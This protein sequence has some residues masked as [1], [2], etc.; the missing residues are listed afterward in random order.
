M[1]LYAR[2]NAWHYRRFTV[3]S[4]RHL[5]VYVMSLSSSFQTLNTDGSFVSGTVPCEIFRHVISNLIQFIPLCIHKIF[6]IT[7]NKT[8][9]LWFY[10]K[11][12]CFGLNVGHHQAKNISRHAACYMSTC[13][14]M[15]IYFAWWQSVSRPKHVALQ[16]KYSCVRRTT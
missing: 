3:T 6:K 16:Y 13:H 11:T 10:L 2:K 15:T 5:R 14:L 8:T 4:V 7:L 12:T 9:Q 1:D